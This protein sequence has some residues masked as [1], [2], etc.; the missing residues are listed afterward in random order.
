MVRQ[1][2]LQRR[3]LFER[4]AEAGVIEAAAVGFVS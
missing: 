1:C 4:G 2:Y 3:F